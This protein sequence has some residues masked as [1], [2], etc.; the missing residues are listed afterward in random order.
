MLDNPLDE[1]FSELDD[2]LDDFE[3]SGYQNADNILQRLVERIDREPLRGVVDALL[4]PVDF[5][6]WWEACQPTKGARVG[7]GRLNWPTDRA[8]RVAMQLVLL[9]SIAT[10]QIPLMDFSF[11]FCYA[12]SRLD[13]TFQE[14]SVRV[15]RPFLRDL[16]KIAELRVSPPILAESV[17]VPMPD[18]GDSTLDDLLR[19]ARDGFRDPSPDTR[20]LALEKLWDAWERLKTLDDGADK[21]RS[22]TQM[23]DR[24]A[25]EPTFRGLLETEA[26]ALTGIGNDFH[27]RHF[28]VDRAPLIN[29]AQV[30]YFFHRMWALVWLICTARLE[31]SS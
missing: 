24:I 28:E 12:G 5:T 3:A 10:T 1:A 18:T 16:V 29:D 19:R 27:I 8:E 23:L 17:A 14:F 26:K 30:D 22:T 21:K 31:S 25:T 20:R 15:M 7:S 2:A 13:D 6:T 9:R 4:P 11:N